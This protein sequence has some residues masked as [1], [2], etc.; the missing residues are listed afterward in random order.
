MSKEIKSLI[1]PKE[2]VMVVESTWNLEQALRKLI[3]TGWTSVPVINPKMEVEGIISK[4]L[5]L[6]HAR[7]EKVPLFHDFKRRNVNEAMK[8]NIPTLSEDTTLHYGIELLVDWAYLPVVNKEKKFIGILTR[9]S[10]LDYLLKAFY[11][12]L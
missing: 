2:K 1:V 10:V 8:R 12:E 4:S 5:I 3:E 6:N 7:L 11:N 9:R